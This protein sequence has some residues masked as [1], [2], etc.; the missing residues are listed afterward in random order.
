MVEQAGTIQVLDG[1][2]RST[3][4]DIAG[5]V[6][7]SE[8]ERG[9]LSMAFPLDYATSGLFYVYYTA[10]APTGQI[11]IEEH[12]VDPANP[13][14]AD[15]SYA[16][17]LVTI[18]HDQQGNHNGGQLQFG[19]DG[20]FTPAP[21]T[22]ASGGDPSGNAQDITAAPPSVGGTA[23]HMVNH[24]YRLG[25]LLRIDPAT[26]AF[27]IFSYGLRNPWRFSY[28]P[29]HR[30]PHHRRRRPGRAT[31][32][33]TSPRRRATAAGPTTAGTTYEGAAHVPGQRAGGQRAGHRRCRSSST[34]TAPACSITGRLR[35]ARPG[36][37]RARR[38]LPLR[39]QLHR[40]HLRRHAAGRARRARWASTWR[41]CRASARTAA[42][43]STQPRSAVPSTAS[44]AAAR[45]PGRRPSSAG[46]L[47]G[48]PGAPAAGPDRRAPALTL[49]RAA[50]RQHALRT[51]FVTHPRALRR[52]VHRERERPRAHQR[53]ARTPRRRRSCARAPRGRRWWPARARRCA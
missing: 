52:A 10:N 41:T 49:L 46:C 3:F 35:G 45:A 47:P 16:R 4:L 34:R 48:S 51:G 15:P 6:G 31:R 1:A 50:A 27:S 17:V 53:A 21:A 43:A 12:R 8:S 38:H 25:K 7:S 36:A 33:S 32:R 28:R 14:R 24:D 11:T 22:A 13:D 26:G 40:R 30:R 19:P 9:L 2:A 18:P 29:Q 20:C 23:G 37:A 39:R 42:G 5:K 44:R